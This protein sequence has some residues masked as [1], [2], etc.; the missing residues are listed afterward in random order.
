MI[1][2][3]RRVKKKGLGLHPVTVSVII[4]VL[5]E[6]KR[7]A[8]VI[9]YARKVH[10]QTE[11]IVVA[12]GTTDGSNLV[13]KRLGARVIYSP[14]PFGLDVG[15]SVGAA[16]AR[17]EIL[18]F[19][20]GDLPIPTRLLRPFVQAVQEGADVALNGQS[21]APNR[22]R[23]HPVVLSKYALNIMLGR[24]DLKAASMTAVPH[25]LHRRVLEAIGVK[26]LSIPPK[27]MAM[28][29]TKGLSI[30]IPVEIPLGRWNRPRGKRMWKRKLVVGDHIEAI[31]WIL[32]LKGV[33]G[34]FTD[35][36]RRREAL[37]FG[38]GLF[39][40]W[41][42]FDAAKGDFTDINKA[43][44]LLS[45]GMGAA[46]VDGVPI[47]EAG[48]EEKLIDEEKAVDGSASGIAFDEGSKNEGLQ[49]AGGLDAEVGEELAAAVLPGR[50]YDIVVWGDKAWN[51]A[52][53]D[54]TGRDEAGS[55]AAP[56]EAQGLIP[57]PDRIENVGLTEPHEVDG[58]SSPIP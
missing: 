2:R 11:V 47:Q 31:D 41:K 27:A 1:E 14:F 35:G 4:P 33:R 15:R 36:M 39:G 9:R 17:G 37:G 56:I 16:E 38:K 58:F 54:E 53:Q 6:R 26:P 49:N 25:A 3:S 57:H 13:A 19:L 34:G 20:D 8:K 10:P 44:S 5:N 43:E 7:I 29:V 50:E 55:D 48:R 22:G 18:L 45:A 51:D 32:Q 21:Y 28:A 42:G 23:V 40:M 46:S 30:K 24:P 12:N 52:A